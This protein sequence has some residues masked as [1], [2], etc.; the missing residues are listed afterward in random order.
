MAYLLNA[1][2]YSITT[3][4][5]RIV[6]NVGG[7]IGGADTE[8]N[9][10]AVAQSVINYFGGLNYYGRGSDKKIFSRIVHVNRRDTKKEIPPNIESAL[11]V[12]L[13]GE[14]QQIGGDDEDV[15][16]GNQKLG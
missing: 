11:I 9:I 2:L 5:S 16:G 7:E 10:N 6:L 15:G 13:G 8:A 12:Q 3:E 14:F 4:S 1:T